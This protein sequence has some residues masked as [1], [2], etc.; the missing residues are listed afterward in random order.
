[1]HRSCSFSLVVLAFLRFWLDGYSLPIFHMMVFCR[2]NL[3][4]GSL[5]EKWS[6]KC[7]FGDAG[8]FIPQDGAV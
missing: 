7:A 2:L 5:K 1:M 8:S 3:D 6:L 4:V